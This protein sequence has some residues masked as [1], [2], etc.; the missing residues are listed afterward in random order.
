LLVERRILRTQQPC[1]QKRAHQTN[2]CGLLLWI[3]G[4]DLGAHGL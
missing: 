2:H 4:R 1:E 3:G